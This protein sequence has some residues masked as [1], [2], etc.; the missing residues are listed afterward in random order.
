MTDPDLAITQLLI[1]MSAGP[2]FTWYGSTFRTMG[3]VANWLLSRNEDLDSAVE[4]LYRAKQFEA[5]LDFIQCGR[6]IPEVKSRMR[7]VTR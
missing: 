5:W 3:D 1:T 4:E 7:E 2:E 6:F